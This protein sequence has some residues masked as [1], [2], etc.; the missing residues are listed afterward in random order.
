[1]LALSVTACGNQ[2]RTPERPSAAGKPSL[3]AERQAEVDAQ[4][5]DA[6]WDNDVVAARRLIEQ[7]ADVNAKDKTEQSAYLI[8]TS[9]GYHRLLR[10][11]LRHGAKV[12]DKDSWNGTGLIRAAE[13]GHGLVVGELLRA[14]IDRD[15]VNRIGYQAIHEAIWLGKDND[16]Y[17]TT[18]RVLAA[19]GV[20][21]TR[22]SVREGLT[23]LQMAE[24]RGYERVE[25][26]METLTTS[27]APGDPDGALTRAAAA[28]DAD[29]AAVALRAGA[30]IEHR[31]NRRRTPLLL[32]A[33]ADHVDVAQLLVAMGA[34][35]DA[36]DDRHDTP[37]L[38]TGVT[39]SV[40]MLEALLPADP[41]LTI[42]NR[43]GGLSIHPA[44][45]RGHAEYVRRVVKTD[46]KVNHV[47]DLGWTGL[48][49]AVVL[50]DGGPRHQDIVRT[51]LANGA[52]QSI[53]DRDG[54]TALD[55]AK[56]KGFA[57][58]AAILEAE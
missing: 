15:H 19:G 42:K 58:I 53:R 29:V 48:L 27:D 4:L 50:G 25:Q 57:E 18:V 9:E 16:D 2:A 26:T 23:P 47:N 8:S 11:T 1:L 56:D 32:A 24:R 6:A 40:P 46:I 35:P 34:D 14:K 12:N 22:E 10:L 41:D 52:D 44:S 17:L 7:G 43:F 20:E 3:S 33:A 55:H 28:G 13:R 51:L 21:L 30:D 39:G 54:Q 45:E 37:W 38:V 31:D 5:R 49:E 36:L